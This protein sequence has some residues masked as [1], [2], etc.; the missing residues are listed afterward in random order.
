MTS[1]SN[2]SIEDALEYLDDKTVAIYLNC[3]SNQIV[4]LQS[5][6]EI[7]ESVGVV[8]TLDSM[9]SKVCILTTPGLINDCKEILEGLTGRVQWE[10]S[11]EGKELLRDKIFKGCIE[12]I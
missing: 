10:Y 8:R 12:D 3:P 11:S 5:Y 2:V 9:R 7:T 1:S 4:Q 6:F